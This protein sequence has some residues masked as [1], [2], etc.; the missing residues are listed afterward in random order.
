MRAWHFTVRT[1]SMRDGT[2]WKVGELETYD[3]KI[4]L[5]ASG[6]HASIDPMDALSYAPGTIIRRVECGGDVIKSD[7]KL[8]C[9]ERMALWSYDA[10]PIL[11]HFARLCALDV[12]HLWEPPPIVVRYLRTGDESISAAASAAAWDD[13]GD[14]ARAAGAAARDARDDAA[15]AAGAAA[16]YAAWAAAWDAAWAARDAARDAQSRRLG[17][18]LREGRP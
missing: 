10:T 14:A 8:V 4:E 3:G 12:I 9:T 1:D 11:R 13:A 15:W 7:D 18:M 5:C 2:P 17:R 6:L 16:G